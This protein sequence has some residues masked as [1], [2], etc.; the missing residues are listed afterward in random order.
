M[1]KLK[2]NLSRDNS[3][4]EIAMLNHQLT[5][6]KEENRITREK[7]Q[8]DFADLLNLAKLQQNSNPPSREL[9]QM[10]L[11]DSSQRTLEECRNLILQNQ[12]SLSSKTQNSTTQDFQN[13]LA[14]EIKLVIEREIVSMREAQTQYSQQ[15]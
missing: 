5:S 3:S 7:F 4:K 8:Q 13:R 10:Q 14:D 1:E 6:L 12:F 9:I 2:E 11:Q 15:V